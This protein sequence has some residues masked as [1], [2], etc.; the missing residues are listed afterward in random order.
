MKK[1]LGIANEPHI[2]MNNKNKM[3]YFKFLAP[4]QFPI[5]I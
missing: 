3:K 5:I 4:T 2:I 1:V